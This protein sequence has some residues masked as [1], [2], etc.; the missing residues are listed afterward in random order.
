MPHIVLLTAFVLMLMIHHQRVPGKH[1]K[2]TSYKNKYKITT[3]KVFNN[4]YHDPSNIAKKFD[5]TDFFIFTNDFIKWIIHYLLNRLYLMLTD[6]LS[7]FENKIHQ[8]SLFS[9][10]L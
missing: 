10:E 3:R 2:Y 1:S 4:D 9:K 5:I 6:D 7:S 8:C